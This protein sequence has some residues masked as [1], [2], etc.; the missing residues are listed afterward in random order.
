MTHRKSRT[1]YALAIFYNSL[2]IML[3]LGLQWR[4]WLGEHSIMQVNQLKGDIK[5]QKIANKQLRLTNTALLQDIEHIESNIEEVKQLARSTLG[6]ID[7]GETFYQL[8]PTPIKKR[9]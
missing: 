9:Y 5:Q 3:L 7:E 6:F 8:I 1:Q 2:L 4:L